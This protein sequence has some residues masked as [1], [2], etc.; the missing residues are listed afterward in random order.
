MSKRRRSIEELA[1][2]TPQQ[3]QCSYG[4]CIM[5]QIVFASYA[6][7]ESHVQ[8]YHTYICKECHKKFPTD[9]FLTLHIEENHDPFFQIRKDK[10]EKTFKCFNY[11]PNGCRKIC[12]D[13][14]KR[15]LHMIDKHGYPRDYKFNIIDNGI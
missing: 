13:R 11:D 6:E 5:N 15:R 7:F 3:I 10:G 2:V 12:S 9:K 8:N 4:G 1:P 14:K